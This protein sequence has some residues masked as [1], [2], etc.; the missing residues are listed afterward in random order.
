V[1]ENIY[2]D[3]NKLGDIRAINRE[4]RSEMERAHSRDQ[5]TELKKRSD[6]LCTLTYSP[7]W[8]EKFGRKSR[9]LR[10]VAIEED[11]RTTRAANRIAES[12]DLG[13]EYHPWGS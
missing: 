1:S 2:G 11:R 9:R 6:Y 5:L 10:E 13:P 12:R 4:I 7:S 8:Q 3:V